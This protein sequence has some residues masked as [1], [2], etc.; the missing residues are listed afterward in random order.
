MLKPL[1]ENTV[2]SQHTVNWELTVHFFH[3]YKQKKP[4]NT[5]SRE[6]TQQHIDRIS[7]CADYGTADSIIPSSK[8]A[9]LV[10]A[11]LI[12]QQTSQVIKT[13]KIITWVRRVAHSVCLCEY[14]Q[15]EKKLAT[16]KEIT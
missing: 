10:T 7:V 4:N 15:T 5:K 1:A 16:M 2:S 8:S 11:G 6:K 14:D 12:T 3:K 13:A 9:P